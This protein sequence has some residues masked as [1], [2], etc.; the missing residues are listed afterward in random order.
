MK[1]QKIDLEKYLGLWYEQARL[2]NFFER[3]CVCDISARYTILPD[4]RI[5]VLNSCVKKDRNKISAKGVARTS[6]ASDVTFEVTFAPPALRFLPFVWANY[7][8]I[9]VDQDYTTALVGEPKKRFLW[10]LSRTK[11]LDSE[12]LDN[13]LSLAKNAGYDLSQL[14]YVRS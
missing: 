10:V 1:S 8:V 13:L 6:Q 12:S 9:F 2:P 3:R 5:E 4:G 11:S 14:I 7:T